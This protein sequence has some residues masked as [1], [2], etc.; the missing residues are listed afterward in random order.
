MSPPPWSRRR[1]VAVALLTGYLALLALSHAVISGTDPAPAELGPAAQRAQVREVDGERH[2]AREVSLVYEDHGPKT[3]APVLVCIHGSP[4]SRAD[5][6]ALA[7]RLGTT[8]RTLLVDLPGFGDAERELPDY[9]IAAHAEYLRQ[10]LDQ[11]GLERVHLLG[12]SM[13]GGVALELAARLGPRVQSV[14]L[15]AS[16][17]VQ[18][19]ELLGDFHLNHAVH[20]LQLG[21]LWFLERCTPHFGAFTGRFFG[22]PYAR[23]FFDTDQRR[24][25]PILEELAAPVLIVHASSD[26]LVPVEAA[27]EHG[28]LL[29]QSELWVLDPSQLTPAPG[30]G[31]PAHI[32][33]HL[34]PFFD[35][36]LLAPRLLDFIARAE[37]G[38]A[39]RREQATPERR[40]QSSEPFRPAEL[41]GMGL[42]IGLVLIA[43]A[44]LVSEDLTCI[45]TGALVAQGRIP[46][47]PGALACFFG[48]YL[49]DLLLYLCGR[50]FGARALGVAPL[51]WFLEPRA[52]ER[53]AKWFDRRGLSAIFLTRFL[54][55]T[56]L[57]TYFAAGAL[58]TR[59][60]LFALYFAIAAGVWT[61]I[62][63]W[64]SS[65]IGGNLQQNVELFERALPIG[66]L[67]TV[68][69]GLLVIKVLVPLC[70]WA[71]RR[72]LRGSYLRLT[73]WE[74]WPAW[75]V[76]PPVVVAVLWRG[77]RAGRLTHF[78]AANPGIQ[79]GGFVGESKS[80][81]L[82]QLA[83]AGEAIPAWTLLPGAQ[84]AAERLSLF[85]DWRREQGLDFPL[86]LKPDAGQRG[87]G[88]L[89]ARDRAAVEAYLA[90]TD[91]D[92]VA[93]AYVPGLEFGVF[94]AR[95]PSEPHG[96]VLS[97]TAK[98]LATVTGDGR[99]T[100][101]ELILADPRAVAM[102][103]YYCRKNA[104]RLD[105]VPAEGE[106]VTLGELGTHA[107]G[108]IFLDGAEHLTPDL[109]AEVERIARCFEGFHFGR[110]DLRVPSPEDLRAGRHLRVLELNGVT[111]EMT[112]IYDPRHSL[113]TGWRTLLRQWE[114]A[115]QIAD[116]QRAAG[117]EVP[118]ALTLLRALRDY[119]R[120]QRSH[121]GG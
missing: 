86:V 25:R 5:F 2:T 33:G 29:P 51:R 109:E 121:R 55:G 71:G 103:R 26:P 53:A 105:L 54:P 11:L 75:V 16:I 52:V 27:R 102:A 57:A 64:L 19:L 84:P 89:V 46:F 76:Y 110:F 93:Q 13:G 61:P 114:L 38:E 50:W 111:S 47:L 80:A 108:A 119:R 14:T 42:G 28:R 3:G 82:S 41:R 95:R 69:V 4:G 8:V 60:W 88:V 66:L 112:H 72:R 48:I 70:T 36:E 56:R 10:W 32:R 90:G 94:Y 104:E 7:P 115:A 97:I 120:G 92:L 21:A 77:L 73:R 1:R 31:P 43:L 99:R 45:A 40:A 83:T 101:E 20:A 91:L 37:R 113:W 87:S 44:T 6:R 30:G 67:A 35:A 24:L 74:F 63:V 106:Q 49:G 116:E 98:H 17:G 15:L 39:T 96:R 59:F 58:R 118:S 12:F 107:R 34:L 100:L 79:Y 85:E 81:I 9:S 68:A 62:L 22:V 117:V 65:A 18:E 78:T 23:N